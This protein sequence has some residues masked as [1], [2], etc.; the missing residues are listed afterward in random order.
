MTL[1]VDSPPAD[2]ADRPAVSAT[3]KAALGDAVVRRGRARHRPSRSGYSIP[4]PNP[5]RVP[6]RERS[7]SVVTHPGASHHVEDLVGGQFDSTPPLRRERQ[8]AAIAAALL[9][10]ER[11]G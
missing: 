5:R 3:T 6:P 2:G 4:I 11:A 7:V 1:S 9:L 10:G 8:A